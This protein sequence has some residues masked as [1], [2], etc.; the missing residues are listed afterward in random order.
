MRIRNPYNW[1]F[2]EGDGGAEYQWIRNHIPLLP[3][4]LRGLIA[5]LTMLVQV[6]TLWVILVSIPI[7]AGFAAVWWLI[8]EAFP[9]G[10]RM[11]G[12]PIDIEFIGETVISTGGSCLVM[13]L[14]YWL[15]KQANP[16][17]R[18]WEALKA[19]AIVFAVAAFF[20]MEVGSDAQPRYTVVHQ[21]SLG[22]V[23]FLLLVVP[24]L[25]GVG[26]AKKKQ[27]TGEPAD[28]LPL[29]RDV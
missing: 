21:A 6:Y 29:R 9:M 25:L 12:L 27:P 11:I 5:W 14:A 19:V 22:V 8:A 3:G 13:L 20:G 4:W 24:A 2:T 1:I 17:Q 7:L 16:T 18:R 23:A 10:M 28:Q 15:G 26:D